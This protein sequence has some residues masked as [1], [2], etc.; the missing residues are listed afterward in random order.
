MNPVRVVSVTRLS[1]NLFWE[2]SY[3]GRSLLRI[4][5]NFRPQVSIAFD[6]VGAKTRGLSEIYNS[7]IETADDHVDLIF[8][9]DD[10]YINDWFFSHRVSDA[11]NKFDLVGVAGSANPDLA[12]PSWGLC[13]DKELRSLG[14]QPGLVRSGLVNHFDYGH[15]NV[16]EY[17][18]VPLECRLL[19][20]VFLALRTSVMKR[21]AMRFD[22]QF[23][24]HCYDLDFCRTAVEKGLRLGTWP[25]ALTH[26]SGG[27]YDSEQFKLAARQYLQKWPVAKATTTENLYSVSGSCISGRWN[28]S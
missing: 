26:N 24:F 17:G 27:S 4:P 20:G 25:I 13:F 7:V 11:L 12:Q 28:A 3:L 21:H 1:A 19:D 14:W 8:L 15:P 2:A 16:S 23:R 5:E 9:H 22:P 18:P 10:V 6:N